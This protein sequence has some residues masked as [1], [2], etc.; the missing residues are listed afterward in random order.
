MTCT[1]ADKAAA[2][3]SVNTQENQTTHDWQTRLLLVG[4]KYED[5]K[6]KKQ[7]GHAARQEV[8]GASREES[9]KQRK[10]VPPAFFGTPQPFSCEFVCETVNHIN[11]YCYHITSARKPN[12]PLNFCFFLYF[13]CWYYPL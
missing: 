11:R 12:L 13:C 2:T 9:L 1:V 3:V 4:C 10:Q 5:R 8:P 7:T 6:K